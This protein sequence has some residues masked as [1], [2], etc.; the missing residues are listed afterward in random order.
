LELPVLERV[1]RTYG[2]DSAVVLAPLEDEPEMGARV[3]P[4]LPYIRAEVPYAIQNEMAMTLSDWMIRRAHIMH[5]TQDQGLGAAPEVAAMMAPH[6]GWDGAEVRRQ[7]EEYRQQVKLS[8]K[9]RQEHPDQ[10]LS[11]RNH[12][13]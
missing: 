3:I 2:P 4:G 13:E 6:L 7:V 12:C 10:A 11:G 5:E 8:R 1:A 9:Y